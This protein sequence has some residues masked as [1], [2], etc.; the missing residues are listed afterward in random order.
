ME[1]FLKPVVYGQNRAPNTISLRKMWGDY[2]IEEQSQGR[3]PLR[4][5]DWAKQNYPDMK[6]LNQ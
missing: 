1:N 4:F 6:I 2:A 5:E 3:D